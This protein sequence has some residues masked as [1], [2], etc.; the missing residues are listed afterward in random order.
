MQQE[1]ELLAIEKNGAIATWNKN[2]DKILKTL[3]DNGKKYGHLGGI[4]SGKYIFTNDKEAKK[5][6]KSET[7]PSGWRRGRLP[8]SD[9]TKEKIGKSC[10]GKGRPKKKLI[11]I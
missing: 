9:S 8:L 1:R 7:I 6:L 4:P 5:V 11:Y 2:K 10:K 3:R